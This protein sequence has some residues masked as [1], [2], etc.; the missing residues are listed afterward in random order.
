MHSAAWNRGSAF[1]EAQTTNTYKLIDDVHCTDK[2][3]A[4]LGTG[5]SAIQ[6]VPQIQK[7]RRCH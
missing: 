3:V 4:V 5:S 6:I 2:R 1:Y 7:G